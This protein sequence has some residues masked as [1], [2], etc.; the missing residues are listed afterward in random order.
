MISNGHYAV[1]LSNAH[2]RAT[3]PEYFT[4][5]AS[6]HSGTHNYSHRTT[7]QSPYSATGPLVLTLSPSLPTLLPCNRIRAQ[8]RV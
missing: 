2:S 8:V 5:C 4:V 1:D 3:L 6:D 7:P